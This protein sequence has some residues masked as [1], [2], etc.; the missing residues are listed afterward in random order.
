MGCCLLRMRHLFPH[1]T[2]PP[3]VQVK[4]FIKAAREL[5]PTALFGEHLSKIQEVIEGGSV[6][7]ASLH[8]ARLL[9]QVRI[10]FEFILIGCD[11]SQ[12]LVEC[13]AQPLPPPTIETKAFQPAPH[14]PEKVTE[15]AK[16]IPIEESP[17]LIFLRAEKKRLQD[18]TDE[19]SKERLATVDLLIDLFMLPQHDEL[20]PPPP[21]PAPHEKAPDNEFIG[22]PGTTVEIPEH[23]GS[24]IPITGIPPPLPPPTKRAKETLIDES[25]LPITVCIELERLQQHISA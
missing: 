23:T 14:P 5:K 19:A 18:A 24:T 15:V 6:P 4:N 12:L 22:L 13:T 25:T 10:L 7:P 20:S 9:H 8:T 11:S 3:S 17:C 1:L 16:E 21:P 2:L